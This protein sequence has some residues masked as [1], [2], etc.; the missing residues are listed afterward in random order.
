[1]DDGGDIILQKY[2][3]MFLLPY[4]AKNLLEYIAPNFRAKE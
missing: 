1:M 3:E 4:N 2:V